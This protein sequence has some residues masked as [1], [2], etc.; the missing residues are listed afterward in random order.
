L[1]LDSV[2]IIELGQVI[3]L[4]SSD[5]PRWVV[6]MRD[7]T[8]P[9]P[10]SPS[11]ALHTRSGPSHVR[12]RL[13]SPWLL[14]I[15]ILQVWYRAHPSTVALRMLLGFLGTVA[16]ARPPVDRVPVDAITSMPDVSSS[17]LGV[18]YAP[19]VEV[20]VIAVSKALRSAST[21]LPAD[22]PLLLLFLS[23]RFC[24]EI[25]PCHR[26]LVLPTCSRTTR[27]RVL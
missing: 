17:A 15:G 7:S 4:I 26:L 27:T 2:P 1:L 14:G 22:G 21:C 12:T 11:E 16:V 3:I 25:C 5:R 9:V 6:S 10:G 13:S 19:Y 23:L 20:V 18:G 24:L 8:V